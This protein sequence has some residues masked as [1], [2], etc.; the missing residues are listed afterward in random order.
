[1]LCNNV[2]LPVT[3]SVVLLA[4]VIFSSVRSAA[5]CFPTAILIRRPQAQRRGRVSFLKVVA[6]AV[7]G[8]IRK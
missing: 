2:V 3:T 5:C 4:V 1:M 6:V 7:D 8:I